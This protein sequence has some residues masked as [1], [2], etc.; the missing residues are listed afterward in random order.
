MLTI[1]AI[2]ACAQERP[3]L[4]T[5]DTMEYCDQL[6]VRLA[7][8]GASSTEVKRLAAEGR[9]MCDHGEIR[10]GIVRLRRALVLQRKGAPPP[11]T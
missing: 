4:I 5:S 9:A 1:A 6:Q 11:H 10:G 2:P 3:V 7:K 8:A